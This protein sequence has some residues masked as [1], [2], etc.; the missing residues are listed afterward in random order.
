MELGRG[1]S[2]APTLL[3]NLTNALFSLCEIVWLVASE[4][5]YNMTNIGLNIHSDLLCEISRKHK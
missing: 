1:R 5:L 4:H 2:V 3:P